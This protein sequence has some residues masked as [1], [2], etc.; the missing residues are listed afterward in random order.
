MQRSVK[1][2]DNSLVRKLDSN[3]TDASRS[4]LTPP[5]DLRSLGAHLDDGPLPPLPPQWQQPIGSPRGIPAANTVPLPGPATLEHPLHRWA[6]AS[7]GGSL[8]VAPSFL[9]P[10]LSEFRSS[11]DNASVSSHFTDE[12]PSNCD[13]RIGRSGSASLLGLGYDDSA[14]HSRGSYDSVDDGDSQMDDTPA[15]H[16]AQMK[17]LTL[18]EARTPPSGSSYISNYNHQRVGSKRRASSPPGEDIIIGN[19]EPTRKGFLLES[20]LYSHARRTP[21]IHTLRTSPGGAGKYYHSPA[22]RSASGSFTSASAS[23]ANTFWSTSIGP[24][25]ATSSITT[26]RTSPVGSFS[27][28]SEIEVVSDAP[29]R[30]LPSTLGATRPST[31]QRTQPDLSVGKEKNVSAPK[32]RSATRVNGITNIYI[33]ECCPKKPKKFENRN[34]LAYVSHFFKRIPFI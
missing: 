7:T 12:L 33:C 26:D 28:S 11:G 9:P 25:S 14:R 27:P 17:H 24:F 5:R 1:D 10:S 29:F 23:S 18:H 19:V 30:Q 8:S 2:Y 31:R 16:V 6:Q 32:Q 34:D 21:P 22:P 13:G 3:T 15:S 4:R 20:D